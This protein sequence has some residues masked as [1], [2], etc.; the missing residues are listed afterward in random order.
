MPAMIA[1]LTGVLAERTNDSVIV[2]VGGVG[3][4]VLISQTSLAE[5]PEIGD[6]VSLHIH[7]HVREDQLLLFGFA[8]EQEKLIFTRLLNVS[9]VGPKMA[10]TILSGMNAHK[11][12]DSVIKED[13]ASLTAIQGIGRKT[14]ERIIIDLKDKFLKEFKGGAAVMPSCKPLYSDA[15]SALMNLGYPK[16]VVDKALAKVDISSHTSLQVLIKQALKELKQ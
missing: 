4:H 13:L 16:P 15:V 5:L 10:L 9:G 14:A 12:V 7:T 3:Y 2:D 6:R 11:I 1:R 8:N